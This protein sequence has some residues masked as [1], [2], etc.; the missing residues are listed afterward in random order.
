[1]GASLQLILLGALALLLVSAGVE[2]VRFRTIGN[3]KN[4]AIA[5]GA[6]LWWWASGMAFWPDI[7][8]QIGCAALV[9]ALFVGAFAL[10]MMGGGD[11]KLIGALALWL[12]LAPLLRMLI[13]MSL[14]GGALTLLMLLGKKLRRRKAQAPIEVPYGVAITLAALIILSEPILNRIG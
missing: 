11:V 8:L 4:A 14:L 9:F 1:M 12:P 13:L 7:T 3:L 10:S 5:L 2:D 6:P